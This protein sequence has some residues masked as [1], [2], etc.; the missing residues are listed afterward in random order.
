MKRFLILFLALLLS[1]SVFSVGCGDGG[2]GGG[3]L[4]RAEL[5]TTY[6]EVA[7]STWEMYDYQVP[8]NS[9]LSLMSASIPDK[10]Q[11]ATEQSDIENIKMNMITMGAFLY[12]LGSLY[13]NDAF[14][15]TNGYAKFSATVSIGGGEFEQ[16][17]LIKSSIDKPNGK[18]YFESIMSLADMSEQY[19]NLVIT[20]DFTAKE[21]KAFTFITKISSGPMTMYGDMALTEDGKYLMYEI[22]LALSTDANDFTA[23]VD[24]VVN[25]FKSGAEGVE[26]LTTDFSSEMQIYFDVL[27]SLVYS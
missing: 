15:V 19:S 10:K 21:V 23:A 12:M 24:V 22:D 25:E 2:N 11:E 7:E 4:T 8:T 9:G 18:I 14:V 20:Y 13:T 3:E 1:F 26:K 27:N 6:K 16:G 5:A 17:Y